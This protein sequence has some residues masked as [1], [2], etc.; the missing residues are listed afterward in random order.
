MAINAPIPNIID[1]YLSGTPAPSSTWPVWTRTCWCRAT[2]TSAPDLA[3][4]E[5]W[6][7]N[8]ETENSG[9]STVTFYDATATDLVFEYRRTATPGTS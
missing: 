1:D 9:G 5:V 8:K 7:I 2:W 6:V 4:N 3:R